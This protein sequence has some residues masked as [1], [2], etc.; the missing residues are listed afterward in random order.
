VEGEDH[1][2][3]HAS[4]GSH[5]KSPTMEGVTHSPTTDHHTAHASSHDDHHYSGTPTL[6]PHQL[7]PSE[8]HELSVAGVVLN[9]L[10]IVFQSINIGFTGAQILSVPFGA[11][12]SFGMA[13]SNLALLKSLGG[14]KN[15][16][17]IL[18]AQEALH[19]SLNKQL[20]TIQLEVIPHPSLVPPSHIIRP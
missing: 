2:T 7:S 20:E 12:T 5:T 3:V 13:S 6:F 8:A 11:L 19:S 15:G 14:S 10:N 9:I 18:G 16:M 1:H 17:L 4:H